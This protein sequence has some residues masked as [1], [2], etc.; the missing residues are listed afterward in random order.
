MV[1]G[2]VVAVR[3]EAT[4]EVPPEIAK[5]TVTVSA[6]DKDRQATLRRLTERAEATRAL[7]DGYGDEVE[8]RESGGLQV[9]PER[10][11]SGEKI[12]AYQGSVTT[13]VTISDFTSLG[14][15]MLRLADQDQTA[16]VGP[17][18]ELRPGS[19]AYREVRRAA[20]ADA[21]VVA[22]DY[23]EALGARITALI[24]VAD[25]GTRAESMMA[26][27][28]MPLAA[29]ASASYT[30]TI[31]LD[32]QQQAVHATI[33]ARFQITDPTVIDPS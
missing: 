16:V 30:P 7:I 29:G 33:L 12:A 8:R 15:L 17:W 9:F 28:V 25:S 5:F 13:T 1:E 18:W 4:R 10:K 14:E 3:G 22:R 20:I 27:G 31:D 26:R 6:R 32:P 24:E 23:A 11:R 2:P 21:L 19:P